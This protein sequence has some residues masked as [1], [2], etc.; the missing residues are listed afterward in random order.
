MVDNETQSKLLKDMDV[1]DK[2]IFVSHDGPPINIFAR[3][4]DGI[5]VIF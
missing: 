1:D 2:N 4:N 3:L 5:N